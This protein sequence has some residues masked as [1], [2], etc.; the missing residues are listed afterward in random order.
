MILEILSRYYGVDIA[1]MIFTVAG[2]Y[3]IGNKEK[4]GFIIASI[5]NMLWVTLGFLSQS[6]GLIVANTVLIAVYFRGFLKWKT[7]NEIES[8]VSKK[9]QKQ[10]H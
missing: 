1:A 8:Q 5:G 10:Q 9:F 3:I 4:K 7:Q 2:L 6:T